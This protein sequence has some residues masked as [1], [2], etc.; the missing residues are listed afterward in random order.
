MNLI[1]ALRTDDDLDI[2]TL[3]AKVTEFERASSI[4]MNSS[5]A[6][7]SQVPLSGDT[8]GA[9]V[10]GSGDQ[11]SRGQQSASDKVAKAAKKLAKLNKEE[12]YWHVRGTCRR[13]DNCP[14]RHTGRAGRDP[15]YKKQTSATADYQRRNA[16]NWCLP[17]GGSYY[18]GPFDQRQLVTPRQ[19]AWYDQPNGSPAQGG[20]QGFQHSGAW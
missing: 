1:T 14:R 12:C 19:L 17:P 4:P 9:Y 7:A 18:T 20:H 13:G 16:D 15:N 2:A 3:S 5:T 6:L 11:A 10:A 8:N